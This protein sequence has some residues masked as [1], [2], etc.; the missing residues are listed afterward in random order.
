MSA[1][2][3]PVFIASDNVKFTRRAPAPAPAP[4][5]APP[6]APALRLLELLLDDP[7]DV[8]LVP[9]HTALPPRV[10]IPGG[11]TENTLTKS[12]F[13]GQTKEKRDGWMKYIYFKVYLA[14]HILETQ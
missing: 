14:S 11:N 6:R 12:S 9:A 4:A 2:T 13:R 10:V 5:L 1:A 3:R 7:L 8:L